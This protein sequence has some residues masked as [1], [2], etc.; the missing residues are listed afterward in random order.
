MVKLWKSINLEIIEVIKSGDVE[1]LDSLMEKRQEI[2]DKV[3]IKQFKK[4][5]GNDIKLDDKIHFLLTN[6]INNIKN[7]IKKYKVTKTA[8]YNYNRNVNTKINLFNQKV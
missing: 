1:R 7:E 2:L 5:L 6:E 8:N 3:D 4:E